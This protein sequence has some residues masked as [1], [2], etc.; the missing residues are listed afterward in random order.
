MQFLMLIYRDRLP[1]PAGSSN[2][3]GDDVDA[4]VM[5][6]NDRGVRLAGEP[7]APDAD[8]VTVRVRGGAVQTD[9]AAF[10]DTGSALFGFDLLDCKDIDEAVAVASEHPLAA[11]HVIELR[12]TVSD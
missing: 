1:V 12:P 10:L 9:P 6:M 2:P 4:W 3:A 7:L 5:R 8:A 11:R